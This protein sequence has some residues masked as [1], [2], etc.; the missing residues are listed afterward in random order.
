MRTESSQLVYSLK[1]GAAGDFELN[2][3]RG[4]LH[5]LRP[6]DHEAVQSSSP[7]F[8]LVVCVYVYDSPSLTDCINVT[9]D[10]VDINDNRPIVHQVRV[11]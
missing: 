1:T 3:I 2:S 6:L 11:D 8:T 7:V 4:E 5:T 10:V 9:V